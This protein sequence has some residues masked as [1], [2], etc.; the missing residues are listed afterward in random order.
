MRYELIISARQHTYRNNPTH[1]RRT[2]TPTSGLHGAR[3][4]NPRYH[5][6]MGTSSWPFSLR[7]MF[8]AISRGLYWGT[9]ELHPVPMPSLPFTSTM[10]RT[11]TNLAGG[12]K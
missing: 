2:A 5:G 4:V 9:K 10:G 7:L 1:S 11:G 3:T 12:K 8:S 6:V